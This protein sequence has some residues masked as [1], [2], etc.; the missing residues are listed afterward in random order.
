[1]HLNSMLILNMLNTFRPW[2]TVPCVVLTSASSVRIQVIQPEPWPSTEGSPC[3]RSQ[4]KNPGVH[5]IRPTSW[6]LPVWSRN[7]E[8]PPWCA[9]FVKV[10]SNLYRNCLVLYELHVSDV[11]FRKFEVTIMSCPYLSL[12]LPSCFLYVLSFVLCKYFRSVFSF[13]LWT[14]QGPPSQLAWDGSREDEEHDQRR[15]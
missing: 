3:R 2:F 7:V 1:M 14:A 13:R 12:L 5:T 10:L 4:G 9:T 15:R 8:P 6:S 11:N